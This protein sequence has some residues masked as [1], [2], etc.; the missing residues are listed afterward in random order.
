MINAY[1]MLV[2]KTEGKRALERPRRRCEDLTM[3]LREIWW[4]VC[5][6]DYLAQGRDKWT[7]LL[8]RVMSLRIP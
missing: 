8:N 1:K 4:G 3:D 2:G 7:V 5:G 6:L